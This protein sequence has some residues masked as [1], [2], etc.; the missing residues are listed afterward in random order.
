[1]E[2][3]DHSRITNS[4]Y[5]AKA[6]KVE[7]YL[8]ELLKIKSNRNPSYL[9]EMRIVSGQNKYALTT[10]DFLYNIA[11]QTIFPDIPPNNVATIVGS[12]NFNINVR[13]KPVVDKRKNKRHISVLLSAPR[14]YY[15]E[16]LG[17][18]LEKYIGLSKK[19]LLEDDLSILEDLIVKVEP[20]DV[21]YWRNKIDDLM[22]FNNLWKDIQNISEDIMR[23]PGFEPGF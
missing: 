12:D 18:P 10:Y 20:D 19:T 11:S 23:R 16:I 6:V 4:F 13:L 8:L 9:Q 21:T 22:Q 7:E 15:F 1:M 3:F 5:K 2:P 14:E 17:Y